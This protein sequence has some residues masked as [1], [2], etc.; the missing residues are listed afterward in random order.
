M[1]HPQHQTRVQSIY[2]KLNLAAINNF[3]AFFLP[4]KLG[5]QYLT[6]QLDVKWSNYPAFAEISA[7]SELCR[8][9]ASNYIHTKAG[10]KIVDA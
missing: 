8:S 4:R 7:R 10:K 9:D 5:S 6:T 3:S 1:D 2:V